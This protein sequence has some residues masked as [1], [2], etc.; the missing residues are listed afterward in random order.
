MDASFEV[1]GERVSG[2]G[3]P[4]SGY[5][6]PDA[7]AL[8]GGGGDE[9]LVAHEER[10]LGEGFVFGEEVLVWFGHT[11]SVPRRSRGWGNF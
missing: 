3:D 10:K 2:I 11:L 8:W 6:Q 1:S 7:V 9:I 4:D 5:T